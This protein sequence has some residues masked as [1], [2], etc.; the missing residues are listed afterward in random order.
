MTGP[1]QALNPPALLRPSGFT[2]AV[3]AGPGRTV[4]LAGQTAHRK[5]GRV[6]GATMVEQFDVAAANA[7]TALRAA[8]AEPEHLVAMQIFTT[9]LGQYR[10]SLEEIGHAYRKHFGRHYPAVSLFEVTSLFD[11]AASVELVCTAVIP[12]T[13]R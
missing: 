8:G 7:V 2:H 10:S 3:V 5:D 1:H 6:S 11:P 4:Y 9:D 12:D 13:T